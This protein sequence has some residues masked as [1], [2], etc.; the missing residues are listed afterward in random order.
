MATFHD[1][2]K[3]SVEKLT[4]YLNE[5]IQGAGS[6]GIPP[7]GVWFVDLPERLTELLKI[8]ARDKDGQ[9]NFN[10]KG[11]TEYEPV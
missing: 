10:A 11:F 3:H 5:I 9:G 1:T 6:K 8:K 2:N 4:K 7:S